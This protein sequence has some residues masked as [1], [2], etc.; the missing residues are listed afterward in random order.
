MKT[1]NTAATYPTGFTAMVERLYN[2]SHPATIMGNRGTI[3]SVL[4]THFAQM[5]TQNHIWK[6]DSFKTLL[7][8]M[9]AKK[10]YA[11]L[12]NPAFIEV[13][14]NMSAFGNKTVRPIDGWVKDSLTPHGQLASLIRHC[15]AAYDVPEFLEYAFA[16]G[17]KIH[18]LWYI[19]LGRGE[20]IQKLSAFPVVFTKAMAHAFRQT[21]KHFTVA[22]AIRRAQAI[23]LGA[24][25]QTAEVVAW[26]NAL[27]DITNVD[28]RTAVIRF[29]AKAKEPVTLDV[30]QKVTEYFAEMY[31]LD[32]NYS[33]KGR[34]WVSVTRQAEA[35]HAELAKRR[36]A[37]DYNGWEACGIAN[38]EV[39]VKHE[40]F[41]IVQ[42]T[43]SEELYDEG[44]DMSHCVADYA[45]D[46]AEG[47]S[48]IFSLRKFVR[49][50]DGYQTLATLEVL[51]PEC[52]IVQA[53][54]RF[55]G[56]I[57]AQAHKIVVQWAVK[58]KLGVDYDYYDE[59]QPPAAI[60]PP[61]APNPVARVRPLAR[62][63]ANAALQR[64]AYR[65]A[66]HAN[67][68]MDVATIARI[69]FIVIKILF[70]LSK[71]R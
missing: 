42:L 39:V 11:V 35:Y 55:N 70:I 56:N 7:L 25:A 27:E 20:S 31:R 34:T 68:D 29:A 6:R 22:Q 60:Q 44:Y 62:P 28:F 10:C 32:T 49:G 63:L 33:L 40:T 19:Q 38:F 58:E 45:D 9:H 64:P 30:L 18:M 17:N 8:V 43:N 26:C 36:A 53:K 69:V 24:T 66:Q 16:D 2:S 61:P 37:E 15:F 5:S 23:G 50:K 46:C 52:N 21:P 1:L 48:A 54:A 3:E 47:G 59:A 71:L 13:L 67:D 51:L 65:P 12:R 4:A 41:R 14:A 57:D